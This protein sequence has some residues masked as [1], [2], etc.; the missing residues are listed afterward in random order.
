[1]PNTVIVDTGFWYALIDRKDNHHARAVTVLESLQAS[2][3]STWPVMTETSYLLQSRL[4]NPTAIQFLRSVTKGL[5]QLYDFSSAQT[6]RM[7]VLMEKYSD[8]PMDFADASLVV[9]AEAL[10]HGQILSTDQRDFNVYRWKDTEP[11]TNLLFSD[12]H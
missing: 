12:H 2:L 5:V 9:L 8:L 7:T 1:M 4:G 10:A 6:T 11:F 3:L